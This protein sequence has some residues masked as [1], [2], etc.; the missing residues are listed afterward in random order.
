MAEFTAD[1]IGTENIAS[2]L[3]S[4]EAQAFKDEFKKRVI[5]PLLKEIKGIKKE[6][7]KKMLNP[8]GLDE[9]PK[10]FKTEIEKY[11]KKI[12]EQLN[13]TV[14]DEPKE[15]SDKKSNSKDNPSNPIKDT[16]ASA[17]LPVESTNKKENEEQKT[18]EPESNIIEFSDKTQRF[19]EGL[20]KDMHGDPKEAE[21]RRKFYKD[22]LHKQ[23]QM[24]AKTDEG[25]F[26]GMIGKLLAIGGVA[27]LLVTAFWDKIKPWLE[28]ALGTKL[29]FLD[30]FKGI[31]EAIGK[32][33]TMGGLKIAFGGIT[34]LVGK[35]FTSFGDLI[36]NVL[37]GAI[38]MILPAAEGVG[39]GAAA[40][41]KGGGIFK[42]LLPKI[43]G[44]LFKG[45]GATVLKGIPLIGSLISLY[46][47]YDRFKGGDYVGAVID[48]VG[49]V[50]NLLEF[51]PLAPLALPISLGAAALNAFL[52]YKTGGAEDKQGA[53]LGAL[54]DIMTGFYGFLKKVPVIGTILNGVEG[55][56]GFVSGLATGDFNSVKGGLEKM[57]AVPL[58]GAVPMFLLGFLDSANIDKK[59]NITG[60]DTASMMDNFKKRVGK[61]ILGWFSWLP[62]SW[63]K[64]IAEKLG[65]EYN[66]ISNDEQ[67]Q[68]QQ[69]PANP[70]PPPVTNADKNDVTKAT[71]VP[72]EPVKDKVDLIKDEDLNKDFKDLTTEEQQKLQKRRDEKSK[73]NY[74]NVNQNNND[75]KKDD[76]TDPMQSMF[77]Q[78]FNLDSLNGDD[79]RQNNLNYI[80]DSKEVPKI[81]KDGEAP[82]YEATQPA[83]SQ[84][85]NINPIQQRND[86][87]QRS[88]LEGINK[89]FEALMASANKPIVVNTSVAPAGGSNEH[90]SFDAISSSRDRWWDYS[91][92]LSPLT[93]RTAV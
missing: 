52:D 86:D 87:I 91:G 32:F 24:L 84:Q 35:A 51:T 77:K 18:L 76:A 23:D 46:F 89:V 14:P 48:L 11:R 19:F 41:A 54:G 44:G 56:W 68:Q 45:I 12:K 33:F 20:F 93:R 28:S 70:P 88:M 16:L 73:K 10:D 31:A 79:K 69:T 61:T 83:Q 30:K 39:E 60:Y 27:T 72:V 58:F 62:T 82:K 6:D 66:G 47:A 50:A 25:G 21:E 8:F 81:L 22:S 4:D 29:D 55:L 36:E 34:S 63:Q 75:L 59:G 78:M 57:A 67:Q 40:T 9:S 42:G 85:N 13:V 80:P 2:L 74:E 49:G 38:K 92:N 15:N 64:W 5:D 1:N 17:I 53:K 3:T 7:I 65:V 90:A 71:G 26:L 43:A 37:K